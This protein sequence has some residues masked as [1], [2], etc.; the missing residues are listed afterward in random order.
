MSGTSLRT[1]SGRADELIEPRGGDLE[2]LEIFAHAA[3]APEFAR[4]NDERIG[5]AEIVLGCGVEHA[6]ALHHEGEAEFTLTRSKVGLF[7]AANEARV[8]EAVGRRGE[9][10]L[11]R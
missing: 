4:R 6:P 10:G 7:A 1:S 11:V 8:G 3:Q 5:G 2:E 9:P